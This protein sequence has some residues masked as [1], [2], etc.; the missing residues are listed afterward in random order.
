MVQKEQNVVWKD[1]RLASVAFFLAGS[2][3]LC[4]GSFFQKL[5]VLPDIQSALQPQGYIVPV[6]YGG[7][8]G[9]LLG[10]WFFQ[11]KKKKRELLDAYES[12]LIGWAKAAEAHDRC[13]HDHA[14]RVVYLFK[15]LSRTMNVPEKELVH[16]GRG[17]LLHDIGKIGIPDK[18]LNK[19]GKLT[20]D[21]RKIMQQHPDKAKKMLAEVEFLRPAIDIPC[22]HHE[23]WD[24]SGYPYGLKGEDIPFAARVFAVVDVWDALLSDRPYRDAWAVEDV[25]EYIKGNSGKLFDPNVV[26]VF[27]DNIGGYVAYYE[28]GGCLSHVSQ[29]NNSRNN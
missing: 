8:T 11:L 3:T 14:E 4:I 26:Q 22:Y 27:L 12:T 15:D 1:R 25:I 19:P 28:N 17:A 23:R 9:L 13:T 2:I 29:T 7:I 5:I 24:G 16:M 18:I 20:E 10:L 6:I 21:E